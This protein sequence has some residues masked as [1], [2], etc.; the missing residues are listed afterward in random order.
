MIGD[1]VL[2]GEFLSPEDLEALLEGDGPDRSDILE[3]VLET[4]GVTSTV[5]VTAPETDAGYTVEGHILLADYDDDISFPRDDGEVRS[6]EELVREEAARLEGITA[7][8]ESSPGSYHVWNLTV[9]DLSSRVLRGL[10]LHGDPMHVAVSWRRSMFVLRCAP[11]TYSLSIDEGEPE[12]YKDAPRLLDVF[13][14]ETD[15]PQSRGHWSLLETL[16]SID[17]RED[18]LEDVDRER[19]EW[20]GEADRVGISRYMT[21]TDELKREV[22]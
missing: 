18:V 15:A 6:R 2:G 3:E 8:F 4:G 7:L 22:W 19:F 12:V 11:K 5:P 20:V 9:E 13:T 17:G 1:D 16:A 10:A 14:S 21:V